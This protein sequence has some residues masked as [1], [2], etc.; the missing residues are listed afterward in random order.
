MSVGPAAADARDGQVA[1]PRLAAR[2]AS[3]AS[4][5]RARGRR[6]RRARR[7]RRSPPR[8]APR[9]RTRAVARASATA[10]G[11]DVADR[12]RPRRRAARARRAW[13]GSTAST[14]AAPSAANAIARGQ[15]ERWRAAAV[16]RRPAPAAGSPGRRGAVA[17]TPRR[18]QAAAPAVVGR[19]LVGPPPGAFIRLR[20]PAVGRLRGAARTASASAARAGRR[21]RA[22]GSAGG[23]D[24]QAGVVVGA[25]A[26]LLAARVP[27][28]CSNRPRSSLIA[29]RW[30][31]I[32]RRRWPVTSPP[33]P[34]STRPVR[35]QPDVLA[36]RRP[37]S[38]SDGASSPCLGRHRV[39]HAGLV[40]DAVRIASASASGSPCGHDDA[41]AVGEQLDGVR[42]RGRD[43][44]AAGGDRVDEDAR[45]DLVPRVV[46]QH[47][48]RRRG[49][50][51]VR[52]GTSRYVSSKS[53]EPATP[54]AHA[55]ADQRLPV[56]RRRARA[57]TFGWVTPAT[58]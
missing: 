9:W 18:P 55:R 39:E 23:D 41:G 22:S 20:R 3:R 50:E 16:E 42:E 36:P 34:R 54:R 35:Q 10:R 46:G 26:V 29:A 37:T 2:A 45:G 48:D 21:R 30:S 13:S 53:T 4:S 7:R 44:R 6:R 11:R 51:R 58:V 17:A 1:A 5:A 12:R 47:D 27:S 8:R 15:R 28:A 43:H 57:N 31:N 19:R 56:L 33:L 38:S 52:L 32:G 40:D 14:S 24:Q 25:V 49:D